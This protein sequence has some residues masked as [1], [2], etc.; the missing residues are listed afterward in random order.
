MSKRVRRRSYYLSECSV[1]SLS[2]LDAAMYC[3]YGE[4]ELSRIA[5]RM[6]RGGGGISMRLK[7]AGRQEF[8]VD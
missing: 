3:A 1:T 2:R 6:R 7:F 4:E 8:K 5:C